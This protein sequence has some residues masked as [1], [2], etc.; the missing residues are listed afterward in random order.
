VKGTSVEVAAD[1]E[2]E[3][4]IFEMPNEKKSKRDK[5][6]KGWK[7]AKSTSAAAKGWKKVM[8]A[9]VAAKK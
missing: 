7:K 3:L 5:A 6:A 2:M 1:E 9:S 4:E 8:G